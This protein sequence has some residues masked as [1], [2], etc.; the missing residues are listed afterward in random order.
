MTEIPLLSHNDPVPNQGGH[1]WSLDLTVGQK[2]L[3]FVTW[4]ED[5]WDARDE[6]DFVRAEFSFDGFRSLLARFKRFRKA[7][8]IEYGDRTSFCSIE[9][10]EKDGTTDIQV[11]LQNGGVSY[12]SLST[13]DFSRGIESVLEFAEKKDHEVL[14][15]TEADKLEELI[16]TTKRSLE[17]ESIDALDTEVVT[18]R[19]GSEACHVLRF[20]VCSDGVNRPKPDPK[21]LIYK[22]GN[23]RCGGCFGQACVDDEDYAAHDEEESRRAIDAIAAIIRRGYAQPIV[24]FVGTP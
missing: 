16:A 20:L 9:L 17:C 23:L 4:Y 7:R 18:V 1:N 21:Y 19:I 15:V 8:L 11:V 6:H 3:R 2:G 14:R 10:C 12:V 5:H 22:F 13:A 24:Q